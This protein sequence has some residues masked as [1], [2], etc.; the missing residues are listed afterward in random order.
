VPLYLL[1]AAFFVPQDFSGSTSRKQLFGPVVLIVDLAG[2]RLQ[3]LTSSRSP[4]TKQK[5]FALTWVDKISVL[6]AAKSQ[7]WGS[8]VSTVPHLNL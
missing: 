1:I 7:C 6:N 4:L 5:T 3:K 2:G 8:S